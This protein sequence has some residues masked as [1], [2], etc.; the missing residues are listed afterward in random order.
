MSK[1]SR[2][3]T[4]RRAVKSDCHNI[5][6]LYSIASDGVADYVWST[7]A[8][9]GESIHDVGLRRYQQENTINSYR[10]CHIASINDEVV[11]MMVAYVMHINT[12]MDYNTLDPVLAPYARLEE[13][14]SYYISGMAVFPHYRGSGIGKQFLKIAEE[15]AKV[16]GLDKLSLIVFEKN[17]G[18]RMLYE[19]TGYKETKREPV[20]PHPLIHFTGNALLLVKSLKKTG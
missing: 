3:I 11:G 4:Y 16:Q 1:L 12:D 7:L 10:N 2:D 15:D 14:N 20:V 19:R 9:P 18:A 17:L 5:V 13:D 8:T 6:R